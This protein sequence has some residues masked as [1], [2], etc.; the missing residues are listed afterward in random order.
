MGFVKEVIILISFVLILCSCASTPDRLDG[1]PFKE[2]EYRINDMS[3]KPE[4]KKRR[5]YLVG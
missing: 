5:P 4:V 2:S 1:T 3:C